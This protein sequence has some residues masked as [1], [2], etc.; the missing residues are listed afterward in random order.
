[1][2][3]HNH[4]LMGSILC[5]QVLLTFCSIFTSFC[6]QIL[7][8]SDADELQPHLPVTAMATKASPDGLLTNKAA[9]S[10][11]LAPKVGGEAPTKETGEYPFMRGQLV[12]PLCHVT[13]YVA[14][15]K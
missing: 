14:E 15:V 5:V 6:T 9:A 13:V 1:M 10:P 4:R 3:M 7:S 12:A 11:A 8:F 2:E